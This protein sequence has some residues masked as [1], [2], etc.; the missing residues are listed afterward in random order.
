M[1]RPNLDIILMPTMACNL[2]CDYCYVLDKRPSVMEPALAKKAIEQVLA[3]NDPCVPTNIYWHGAEP[4]MAGID[5]YRDICRWIRER[6]GRDSVQHRIQ[7]NGIL[8]N[9]EWFDFFIEERITTGVSLDGPPELHDAYRKT[10]SGRGTF[11]TVFNNIMTARK[12]KL[13]F[14]VLCVITRRT[15]GHED[16]LFNFFYE[17]KIDFGFEPI[18]PENEHM[19]REM[20]IT[21]KDYAQVAI[22][23]FD[24]WFFQSEQRLKTVV[25]PYH[26]LKAILEG[27]NTYCNFSDCCARNYLAVSPNGQIH[28]CIL[29]ARHENLSFGNIAHTSLQEILNSPVRQRFLVSRTDLIPRCQQCR[30]RSLCQSGCPQH[31][32][33]K[34]GSILQPD[35][36]CESYQWIFDHVCDTVTHVLG[37]AIPDAVVSRERR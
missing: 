6:Y 31:A 27:G 20:S 16:E 5:F 29:F 4:L 1:N 17:H 22:K 7:T 37:L 13:Y 14:D 34:H 23:L 18:I 32:F 28:S 36:F 10:P 19:E 15:L 2:A 35:A 12:K 25:P 33:I 30:W 9:E 11:E 21:P 26:F 24:H 3:Y 8:L